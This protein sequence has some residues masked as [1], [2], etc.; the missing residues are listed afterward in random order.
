[1]GTPTRVVISGRAVFLCC[2]GCEDSL[3]QEPA[4]YLAKLSGAK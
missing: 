1:M 3:K 4:K 2:D